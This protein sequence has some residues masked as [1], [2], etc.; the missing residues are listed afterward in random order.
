MYVRVSVH[1]YAF[2]PFLNFVGKCSLYI[3]FQEDKSQTLGRQALDSFQ[4]TSLRTSGTYWKILV[5]RVS[6]D[7]IM[8]KVRNVLWSLVKSNDSSL[9]IRSKKGIKFSKI[10]KWRICKQSPSVYEHMWRWI[11]L[12]FDLYY[13]VEYNVNLSVKYPKLLLIEDN[14][15]NYIF[16]E[17]KTLSSER[18]INTA[19]LLLNI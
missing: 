1:T 11:D 6:R 17:Q 18:R 2:S 7:I 13:M 5:E 19:K 14:L 4:R 8:T 9:L 15:L 16:F 12:L 3:S 10:W